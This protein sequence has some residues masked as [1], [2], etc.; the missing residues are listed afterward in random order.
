MLPKEC[1]Q[2]WEK[3]KQFNISIQTTTNFILNKSSQKMHV[4]DF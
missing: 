4:F 2:S 3:R 1:S